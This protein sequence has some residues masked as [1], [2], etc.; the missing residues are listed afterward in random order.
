[1][2]VDPW[3]ISE[4]QLEPELM[5]DHESIFTLAN[6]YL[7][8][9]GTLEEMDFAWCRGTY[10]NGFYESRP[11]VYG[12]KAYGY[13][14]HS[15]TILNVADGRKIILEIG[16]E[17][18]D[19][20]E[21]RVLSWFREIDV[22]EGILKRTVEWESPLEN[23]VRIVSERVVP[24]TRRHIAALRYSVT[25]LNFSDTIR[26]SSSLDSNV[27]NLSAEDDPRT[28]S[29]LGPRA[30]IY[31]DG[32]SL[33][34]G[35]ELIARTS[36]SNLTMA[37]GVKHLIREDINASM[38]SYAEGGEVGVRVEAEVAKGQSLTLDKTVSYSYRGVSEEAWNT[39]IMQDELNRAFEDG[40]DQ[41]KKE[42]FEYL[43]S[44]WEH[45]DVR[46]D[47]NSEL[48]QGIRFN[49][50]QL[51]QSVGQNGTTS[52]SAKGLTGEGYEGHYFWDTE[53]YVL[54]LFIY[55]KPEIA[56]S[57]L[58]YRYSTL[59]E[60][61]F[62]AKELSER[63]ALFPW[64]T[65]NG[66]EASAY[67]PAGT[68]QYHI[69]ADIV[70]GIKKFLDITENKDYLPRAAELVIETARMWEGLGEY[71]PKRDGKFCINGVT[72]PDEYTALVNNNYYTNIMARLNLSFAVEILR[73][74]KEEDRA[75]YEQVV[76]RT[77]LDSKEIREWQT[78]AE[79]MYLP[80]DEE[81]GIHPQDDSFLNK[82]IWPISEIPPEKR[83]LLLHYHPLVIY[84]HQILKQADL[85]LA[86]FLKGDS[87]KLAEKRRDFDYYDRLTT[88]DSSLSACVQSVIAAEV[89]HEKMAYNYFIRTART[90]LD[91]VNGNVRDGLHIAAMAGTWTSVVYGFAGMRDYDGVLSFQPHLPKQWE[92]LTFNLNIRG[93]LLEVAIT[94]NEV[95]YTLKEGESLELV[96][97][98]QTHRVHEGAPLVFSNRPDLEAVIFDLDGVITDSAE[99]HYQAWKK[100]GE[101][102]G[103]DFDR[104]FNHRLRGVGRMD[105]LNLLLEKGGRQNDF[106]NA[107][108]QEMATRKNEYYKELIRQ[109][110]PEDLLPGIE[111][112]LKELKDAGIKIAL[113]SASRNAG[114]IIAQ[115]QVEE[116]FDVI[117]DP[118]L[119]KK[120]KPDP[121]QFFMAAELLGIPRRNCIGVEDAQAGID[122]INAA[123]MLSVGVGDYLLNTDW[124]CGSTKGLKLEKLREVFYG[125][126]NSSSHE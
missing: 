89:G 61:R 38:S 81:I 119:L 15:Q 55:T 62:R 80:Y 36:E 64:R 56:Q 24:L 114:T 76:V 2:K 7:G 116:L 111:S 4:N 104:E 106:S 3:K 48:Q 25:P 6:G 54:P 86:L 52:I 103:I 53:I 82:K 42:E 16:D 91:N 122:A 100:L 93:C 46:I 69:N 96:H 47:G 125:R 88:G 44:F 37:C 109:I 63:G 65:I 49:L 107:E 71:I 90:D 117:T 108:K 72:G 110:R 57:L 10:L 31:S 23:R 26:I 5:A 68:A 84:R 9:R 45:G 41:L 94:H 99:Y 1:M 8:I 33:G 115:L 73:R 59:D 92:R 85:V 78:A 12:E 13:P 50:F 118:A 70:Y 20:R 67:Y 97:E 105:S 60:A 124:K 27:S 95:A 11:I 58:E 19:L 21:G 34:D 87:F 43:S 98:G 17:T 113:A 112:L 39:R 28:G 123:G 120:G 18:F 29:L 32:R 22:R 77:G 79:R 121:E 51:L 75:A 101:E 126:G 35:G 74:L 40:I 14:E 83:P 102:L 30:L 66:K